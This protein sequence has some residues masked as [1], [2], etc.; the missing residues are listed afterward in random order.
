MGYSTGFG[1]N[2]HHF[3][4]SYSHSSGSTGGTFLKP[5]K[6]YAIH[7]LDV[8]LK[9]SYSLTGNTS[10]TWLTGADWNERVLAPTK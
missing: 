2:A 8:N 6:G 5:V 3:G 4:Y 1:L 10:Y 7:S 9:P